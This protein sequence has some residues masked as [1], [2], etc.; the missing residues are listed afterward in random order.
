MFRVRVDLLG[1]N[2]DAFSIILH[3]LWSRILKS[4]HDARPMGQLHSKREAR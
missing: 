1:F 3:T 2:H 4:L